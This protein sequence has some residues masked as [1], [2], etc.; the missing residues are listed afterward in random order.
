[1]AR[2]YLIAAATSTYL[3]LKPADER[4][5]LPQVLASVVNLFTKTLGCYTRELEAVAENSS[6]D[7]LRKSL[8]QWFAAAERDPSD[9]IVLYYTG[10]AEV[11]GRD[12]LYLLTT[13][14]Q[15]PDHYVGTAFDLKQI[16]DLVLTLPR[17]RNLLL[18]IDTCFAGVATAELTS[19]LS[20]VFR[21][22][23]SGS[24]YLL[25]AALPRQ[26]AKAGALAKALIESV[27]ELSR[28]YVSQ[29]V[30]YLEQIVPAIN[31]RLQA[32]DAVFSGVSSPRENPQFFPNP[33]F[34]NTDGNPV[35]ANE[36]QRAIS[37]REFREHW[38]PRSRGV[39][40]DS[41]AGSYF[42]GRKNLL[43]KLII[44]L[45]SDSDNRTRVVTGQPGAGKSAVLSRLL[46]LSLP[47]FRSQI[48]QNAPVV[49]PVDIAIH[50]R[51]KTLT[52][53]ITRFAERFGVQPKKEAIL[54]HLQ[55]SVK[56]IRIIVDALD[57]AVD[58]LAIAEELLD[59][60]SQFRS[61]KLLV[62][63]RAIYSQ[64]FKGAEIVDIDR[65][66]YIEQ[67][68]I[69]HYVKA[70]LLRD[71]EPKQPTPYKGKERLATRVAGMVADKA[72]PNYL[73]ARIVIEDLLLQPLAVNPRSAIEI[74]FPAK[75]SVAFDTYLSRFGDREN[76]VRDLLLPLAYA[77]GQGLPWDN[78]W[79]RLA[80]VF[81]RRSYKDDDVR[82][83]LENA[84][85]FVLEGVS[86]GRSVYRL[87]HEA[88]ADV[89]RK[90]R[91]VRVTHHRFARALIASTPKRPS[92]RSPDWLT[93]SWYTRSHLATHAAKC[94]MLAKLMND[95]LYLVAADPG[96]LLSAIA[97]KQNTLSRKLVA[98]YKE[99]VNHIREDPPGPAASY[100]QLIA[101]Q[102]GLNTLADQVPALSSA[103]PWRAS[104]AQ[105]KPLTT[106]QTF[107][108]GEAPI[109]RL[110]ATN[111]GEHRPV[112][113]V[114]R[115]NGDVEVWDIA[116][117]NRLAL[118]RS[119]ETE[120]V[121]HLAF[122]DIPGG[123]V[124]I[125]AWTNRG[126]GCLNLTTR[127]DSFRRNLSGVT[128]LCFGQSN[129][130]PVCITAD[131]DLRLT[132]WRLSD[133]SP[134]LEKSAATKGM[135]YGLSIAHR[136]GG[137]ALLS[138][139]DHHIEA[140]KVDPSTLRLWSLDDLSLLW[141]DSTGSKG[142][143]HYAEEGAISDRRLTVISHDQWAP[144]DI[145]D[146]DECR[147]LYHGTT[148]TS[149]SWIFDFMGALFLVS[150]IV[151]KF[152]IQR[153][154]YVVSA[155]PSSLTTSDFG[156]PIPSEG[157]NFT[158]VL[159]LNGRAH[160][161][162]AVLNHVR[163]W[164]L[165]DLV[166]ECKQ[167]SPGTELEGN[168]R[169]HF[170]KAT[171]LAA[172][173]KTRPGEA[174]IGDSD[175]RILALDA[176]TGCLLWEKKL[177]SPITALATLAEKEW[178][179]AGTRDGYIH[180]LHLAS[181][182]ESILAIKVGMYIERLESIQWEGA[183]LAFVTA[184]SIDE[185]VWATRVWNLNSG[186]EVNTD[187]AYRLSSGQED[188]WMQGLALSR[189][190]GSIRVA[191]A[192]KYSKVMVA[193]F[194]GAVGKGDA[195]G[196]PYET[197]RI[198]MTTNEY[199]RCLETGSN[200]DEVILA[201]GT[202]HGHIFFWNFLTGEIKESRSNAHVGSIRAMR[203]GT[204]SGKPVLVSGGQDGILKFWTLQLDQL[205]QIKIGDEILAITW[206][207]LERLAIGCGRGVIAVQIGESTYSGDSS[208]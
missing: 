55:R 83:L 9:W 202:E 53:L 50:A 160:V 110:V 118:W 59:P 136:K 124:L 198:P 115:R 102:R 175:G 23:S 108:Y 156:E 153:L 25:G 62:G 5:Q 164:D 185:L 140:D 85:S 106:N 142:V 159:H 15:P 58:P 174:Y 76:V 184:Q 3:N 171:S 131:R 1:M 97:V 86:K 129:S 92:E 207:G 45:N 81:A 133:L 144:P 139:G 205:F 137:D 52:E 91:N 72:F 141:E 122:A 154:E 54:D 170:A 172:L 46:N 189:N 119:A 190:H 155:E 21:T 112:A 126:L 130:Q 103:F 87:Y 31:Q 178:L 67:A 193:D 166:T 196:E 64:G 183:N 93:A 35:P 95:P 98:V 197:W 33:S 121:T 22:S 180:V 84:G 192:S 39:E 49:V 204:A 47:E 181:A 18:I 125:A 167:D 70:R 145:W 191:F 63:T 187:C 68:D 186:E 147:A 149:R 14:F 6:A 165:G 57:E 13:D 11:V 158:D 89:L 73:V 111:W 30:L 82:W 206:L 60:L 168:G 74:E 101:R 161:L 120:S 208:K 105:W 200:S 173:S 100:L 188:K 177:N 24:F 19:R 4:P 104:W 40:F 48:G 65:P 16:S 56:L 26:E 78:I 61:V 44:F 42:F 143:A 117:G 203:F 77:E 116:Q 10:H 176:A 32:H 27:E 128:A 132:L 69:A 107:G 20:N 38:G 157:S 113:L 162:S 127:E 41:Q 201:A 8:N 99:S 43:N 80:S 51:A 169:V 75:I 90:K 71:D 28:R 79:A 94:G 134:I 179:V 182:D 12:S 96:P 152:R 148:A 150:D 151:E 34:V 17:V 29:D 66:E 37:D 195:G 123:P 7:I 109:S 194:K 135:I 163:L 146:L 36:A 2:H 88:L 138:V 199:V 114:G